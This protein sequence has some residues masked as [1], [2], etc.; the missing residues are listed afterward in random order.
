M[1][2]QAKTV[3]HTAPDS[4][5]DARAAA[6]IE[7]LLSWNNDDPAEHRATWE[8]VQAALEQHSFQLRDAAQS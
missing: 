1:T 6:L 7:L 8:V 4:G 3:Q 5:R 2:H